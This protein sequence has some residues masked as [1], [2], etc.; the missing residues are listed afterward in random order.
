MGYQVPTYTI[1]KENKFYYIISHG[2]RKGP[3]QTKHGAR[4]GL[5]EMVING[6]DPIIIEQY[7]ERG[8]LINE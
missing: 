5:R 2:I 8:R 6:Q 3:Y 1:I 4:K 7:D